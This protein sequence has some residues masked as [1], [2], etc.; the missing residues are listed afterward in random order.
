MQSNVWSLIRGRGRKCVH[1]E[2]SLGKQYRASLQP[3]KVGSHGHVQAPPSQGWMKNVAN[4]TWQL[5]SHSSA[6]HRPIFHSTTPLTNA[7]IKL[8]SS[9]AGAGGTLKNYSSFSGSGSHGRRHA[10]RFALLII[11][12]ILTGAALFNWS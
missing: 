6:D 3:T 10:S 5:G 2:S 12:S 7:S 4:S 11:V 9:T 8:A 1:L